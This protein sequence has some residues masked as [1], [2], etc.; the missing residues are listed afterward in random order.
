VILFDGDPWCARLAIG[1]DL[2]PHLRKRIFVDAEVQGALIRRVVLHWTAFAATLAVILGA[3]QFFANPLA[4]FDEHLTLFPRRHGLTFIVLLLLLPAFLWDTARLSHR[5]SGPV[6]R[7]RRMMK[8]LAGGTDPGELRF[9][10]GDF[11]KELGDYFNGIRS[12]LVPE[13]GP[14]EIGSAVA[15]HELSTAQSSD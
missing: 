11:W 5:F 7:L 4:S 14:G 6:L 12:R 9:R 2:M 10:D 15:S 13:D 8:E 1:S 3:V